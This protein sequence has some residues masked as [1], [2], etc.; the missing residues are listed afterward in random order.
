MPTTKGHLEPET[1]APIDW[2]RTGRKSPAMQLVE[3]RYGKP[4][5]E[6]LA[7]GKLAELAKML[8]VHEATICRWRKRLGLGQWSP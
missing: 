3:E 7:K 4:L 6:L 8:G 2:D 5:E 1:P